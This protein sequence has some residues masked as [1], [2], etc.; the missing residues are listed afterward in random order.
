M[1]RLNTSPL[2][3]IPNSFEAT[4]TY[5]FQRAPLSQDYKNFKLGDEWLDVASND[6]FKLAGKTATSATWV[7]L[8]GT[9]GPAETFTGDSGGPVAPDALNDITIT[10]NPDIDVVGT[11]ASNN[12][13]L[14]NLTK[15]TP[16]IVDSVAGNAPY[17]TIQAALN[18]I[19]TA[20]ATGRVIVRPGTYTEDLTFP[21]QNVT[22][23][24]DRGGN[25]VLVGTHIPSNSHNLELHQLQ[26]Q[27]AVDIFNSAGAGVGSIEISG[28][29]ISVTNGFVFNLTNWTGEFLFDDCGE[30]STNDGVVNNTAG[31]TIKFLNTEMGAGSGQTMTLTGNANV[32]FDTCNINCPINIGG[33]GTFIFQNGCKFSN[34]VTIGGTKSGT[35]INSSFLTGANQALIYNSATPGFFSD[36]TFDSSNNPVIG[37]TGTIEFGQ[38]SFLNNSN[39]NV[40]LTVT[41]TSVVE[42]GTAYLQDIS[43][44]RGVNTIDTDGEL[45]IGSTGNNPQIGTLTA[46]A[47]GVAIT[48]GAGSIT[49][50]LSDDLAALE[51]LATTGIASRTA[52]STWATRTITPPAAGITIADGDG[53]AGN[54]T[55][56]LTDDLGAIEG[57]ATNGMAARTGASTWE[58]RTLTAG[59][60]ISIIDGD[61]VS[62]N[63][64]ISAT[65]AGVSELQ[66]IYVGKHGN[67]A[68]SGENIEEAKL[69]IAAGITAAAAIAP[70]A[71]VI[72]DAGTYSENIT[73]VTNVHLCAPNA[74][75]SGTIIG[76]DDS[77]VILRQL[78]VATATTGITK[79][80]GTG[81][82][83]CDID[84]IIC[85]GSGNGF[86]NTS[87]SIFQKTMLIS[88]VNG[89]GI[90]NSTSDEIHI[91]IDEIHI[92][93]SGIGIGTQTGAVLHGTILHIENIGAGTGTGI[94]SLGGDLDVYINKMNVTTGISTTGTVNV[95]LKANSIT[96][97]TAFSISSAT[98]LNLTVNEMSG[99]ET[100][101]AG[102][103]ARIISESRGIENVS[104]QGAGLQWSAI[105]ASQ[106]L[107]PNDGVVCTAGAA[108]VLTLPATAKV[109]DTFEAVLDG[110]TSWQ[111]AQNAGQQ[112]RVGNV[113]TTAGAGGSITSTAQGDWIQIVCSV[114]NTTFVANVKEGLLTIV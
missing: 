89:F 1:A 18:A 28:C 48:N 100:I 56:S 54:P 37:G 30:A 61:G 49:F 70:A 13:Q 84:F 46:P 22:L 4:R 66:V 31:A 88:L 40:G 16:Y 11:P 85:S 42:G 3:H 87:G 44:D 72:E 62:G 68:N 34:T 63:P 103:I 69:T 104:I 101:T 41:Y 106:A 29:F 53:V 110:A 80:T 15:V 9:G 21:D 35:C 6:W 108:L 114:A 38:V 82:F 109:G 105:G 14:T 65:G 67:D 95:N 93:G 97:T 2:T 86:N 59:A 25:V 57:L 7:R 75:I 32:R 12:L 43:F 99:T 77:S 92:S 83:F 78:T 94:F 52:A 74:E 73:L 45:I 51:G 111:I 64:T 8:G 58:T 36:V 79:S 23:E 20:G 113:Q 39:I 47:S 98:V 50:S 17:Q 33:T 112:I 10:G 76:V 26:L 55:L 60:G 5:I 71:V 96:A 90:A 19:G 107:V 81:D 24:G 27:D 91:E 102:G